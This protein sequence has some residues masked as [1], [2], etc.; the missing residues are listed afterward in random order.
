[1]LDDDA[2]SEILPGPG[3]MPPWAAPL[4]DLTDRLKEN[5]GAD[6]G[7]T[8]GGCFAFAET[9]VETF[10]GELWGV[11]SQEGSEGDID[12]PVEHAIVRVGD[13]FYDY[14]GRLDVDAYR[15]DLER[16]TGRLTFVKRKDDPQVFWFED[17]YLDDD[18]MDSLK[19]ALLEVRDA[20][21]HAAPAMA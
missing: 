3:D 10:G 6:W 7:W 2:I 18:D 21:E 17:E 5:W 1:M 8:R 20:N 19:E 14:T 12:F 16:R 11:C 4:E 9:F 15:A 13:A